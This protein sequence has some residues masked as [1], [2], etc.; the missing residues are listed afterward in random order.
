MPPSSAHCSRAAV[1]F[2]MDSFSRKILAFRIL[3]SV[4]AASTVELLRE[5]RAVSGIKDTDSVML[6][7]DGGSENDNEQVS[8]YLANTPLKH[9]IAQV[10]VSFSNSLIEAANK[11]LKYRYIFRKVI[12][13][14]AGFQ[15]IIPAS[16]VDYNDRPHSSKSGLSPNE[17][18]AG[19]VF[20]KASYRASLALAH[21]RRVAK[22][23]AS[24]PPCI[25]I[26]F[27]DGLIAV[28]EGV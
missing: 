17:I 3:K 9:L 24:C 7:S 14:E 8:D 11:T 2:V 12:Q 1:Q 19:K 15:T 28:T 6:I 10:D 4:S 22:N 27:D 23:R 5:A 26:A 21:D 16:I 18:Y 13:S 20:D 25:P